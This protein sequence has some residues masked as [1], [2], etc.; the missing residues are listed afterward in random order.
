MKLLSPGMG[1]RPLAVVLTLLRS[2]ATTRQWL[3]VRTDCGR[4]QGHE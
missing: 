3:I 4:S 1:K 2:V